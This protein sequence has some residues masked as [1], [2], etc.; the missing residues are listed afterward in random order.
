M[1]IYR[2]LIEA[3]Q[4]LVSNKLRSALTILGIVIGVAAVIAMISLGNGM[5]SAITESFNDI[6]T[7]QLTIRASNSEGARNPQELTLEDAEAIQDPTLVSNVAD[8]APATNSVLNLTYVSNTST[9]SV[10]G[11]WPSYAGIQNLD[12]AEGTFIDEGHLTQQSSVVV[13]GNNLAEELFDRSQGVVGEIV[14]IEGQPYRVIGVLEVNGSSSFLASPDDSAYVPIS[15]AQARLVGYE[16]PSQVDTIIVEVNDADNVDLANEQI[17]QVLRTRHRTAIG[18]DDF[19]VIAPQMMLDTL[20]QVTD[21]LTIFL[22][23]IAGISLLVGGIGIMNIM[24]VS[25]TERTREIGLRKALGARKNDIRI[26]FISESVL[27]SLIGGLV[28]ILLGWAIGVGVSAIAAASDVVL[29][30]ELQIS[31]IL[32]ATLFASAIGVFFGYYPA[33]RAASLQPVEALRSE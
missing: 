21:L 8:V 10:I 18:E 32:L 15:T 22:G 30:F 29:A 6:G 14:R 25:V 33:N 4:S 3:L 19:T 11:T 9:S 17:S 16:T 12:L 24:L 20:T 1:N 28:G 5:E 2:S 13:L 7:T 23:G 26:Q 31:A 27:L